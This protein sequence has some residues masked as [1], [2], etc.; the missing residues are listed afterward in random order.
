MSGL[1]SAAYKRLTSSLAS[2][3]GASLL[4]WIRAAAG[5][6]ACTVG[7]F[8]GWK[9]FNVLEFMTPAQRADYLSGA[10][11]IDVTVPVQAAEDA[12]TSARRV[13]MWPSGCAL[14]TDTISRATGSQWV[15][16]HKNQGLPGFVNGTKIKFQ[17]SSV[18]PLWKP[19]GAPALYRVGYCTD[20]FHVAGNANMQYAF[21]VHGIN[22]SLFN[23][24]TI[25]GGQYGIRCY[26]T[27]HNT[28]E[29]VSI[30][31]SS[32]ASVLY[33]G[34]VCTTDVW[35]RYYFANA[36]MGV[37]TNGSN[38][39]IRFPMGTVESLQNIAD[40]CKE[41]ELLFGWIHAEDITVTGFKVGHSGVTL[42]GGPQLSGPT[43]GV[44][45]GTNG[46]SGVSAFDIDATDGVHIGGSG[47][48]VTRWTNGIA[49]TANTLTGQIVSNGWTA[50]S[51]SYLITDD[52]KVTGTF[53]M[54]VFNGGAHNAQT[55]RVLSDQY[56]SPG[57]ACTGAITTN[58]GWSLAKEGNTVTLK[59]P[60]VSGVASASPSFTFADPIPAKYRPSASLAFSCPVKDNSANQA[61][62]GVI[63]VDYLSGN[64]SIYRDG[65]ST[66]NFTAGGQAG[67]GMAAGTVISWTV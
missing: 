55:Q 47:L 26:G 31:N 21:D 57:G 65:T 13:L 45:G 64:V 2:S 34:G 16:Q 38:V 1:I 8:L 53:P 56:T 41:S 25:D 33:D 10:G 11:S 49:A 3:S 6:V 62:P 39:S 15:G 37:K 17:P 48:H 18:K 14:I 51:V 36:P 50:S 9:E 23:N 61:V 52:T 44:L 28:Y 59:L 30:T 67:I 5:A 63:S 29:C 32:I 43:A 24:L 7:D 40:I 42:R 35:D 20:G 4:G 54:T 60:T 19:S 27:I 66:A 12:A 58:V 22:K 46:G